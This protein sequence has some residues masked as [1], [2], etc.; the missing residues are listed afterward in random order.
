MEIGKDIYIGNWRM[1]PE[2]KNKARKD[3][4]IKWK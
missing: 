3:Y 2:E 4:L 1:S